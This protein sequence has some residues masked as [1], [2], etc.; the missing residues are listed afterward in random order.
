MSKFFLVKTQPQRESQAVKGLA[1][2]AKVKGIDI[3]SISD[4][5]RSGFIVAEANHEADVRDA[6][7]G[8]PYLRG[9][10]RG[11][12][13]IDEF[14]KSSPENFVEKFKVGMIAQVV[15][16]PFKG[17][18]VKITSVNIKKCEI[19]VVNLTSAVSFVLKLSMDDVVLD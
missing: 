6:I 9:V 8:T 17:D 12:I 7:Y 15:K 5:G 18:K 4:L 14:L 1:E 10:V 3:Y 2:N 11:D 13:S 16:P 19:T